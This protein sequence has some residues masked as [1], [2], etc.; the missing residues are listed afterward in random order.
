[1]CDSILE[2]IKTM[3]GVQEECMDFDQ[4]IMVFINSA[5]ATLEQM[6][7]KFNGGLPMIYGGETTWMEHILNLADGDLGSIK[8]YVFLFV[9]LLFDP[10]SN[11]FVTQSFQSQ[12]DELAW[13]IILQRERGRSE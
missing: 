13:R 5:F 3:L 12:K 1:M 2:T 10:P 4:Q 9:R 8:T 7:V 6:G 11:S